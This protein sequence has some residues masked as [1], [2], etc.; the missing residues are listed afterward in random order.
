MFTNSK[1]FAV[2]R[3]SMELSNKSQFEVA[4]ALAGGKRSTSRDS[5]FFLGKLKYLD[6]Q[7]VHNIRIRNLS[8]TGMMAECAVLGAIDQSV[9]IEIKVVG[10]IAGKI[11]W[12]T[13]KR[14]GIAFDSPIDSKVARLPIG[15]GKKE[16]TGLFKPVTGRRSGLKIP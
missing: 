8:P 7:S 11:A 16:Q 14:M 5:L 13:D 12:I 3:D 9:E 10:V 2:I 15:T 6:N 1:D 4:Q